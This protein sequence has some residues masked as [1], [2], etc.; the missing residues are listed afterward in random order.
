MS[1]SQEPPR[2]SYKVGDLVDFRN[3][4][5]YQYLVLS[6]DHAGIA[7]DLY[8]TK[9]PFGDDPLNHLYSTCTG[10]WPGARYSYTPYPI[11]LAIYGVS[12]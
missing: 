2:P 1:K 7:L 5:R 6:V 12:L 8:C 9:I 11:E 10:P 3:D 4:P